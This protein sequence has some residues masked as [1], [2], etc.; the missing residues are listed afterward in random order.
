MASV[1]YRTGSI[2][3]KDYDEAIEALQQARDQVDG[4]GCGV[5]GDSGHTPET[6]H[7]NPLILARRYAAATDIYVC[8]HCGFVAHNDEEA[9]EHFG[10]NDSQVAKCL[11]GTAA[12]ARKL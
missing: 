9:V 5:C 10:Q 12:E 2:T 1:V 4:Y 7:H 8:Y 6:C 11:R 3:R